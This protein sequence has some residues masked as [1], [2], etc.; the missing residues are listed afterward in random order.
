LLAPTSSTT[1]LRWF[2]LREVKWMVFLWREFDALDFF[3]LFDAAL[4]FRFG[5]LV[6]KAV[7]EDFELLDASADSCGC[8]EL[9]KRCVFWSRYLA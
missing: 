8:G 6:A 3:Q 4:H 9:L 1:L 7:D 2:G 5:R